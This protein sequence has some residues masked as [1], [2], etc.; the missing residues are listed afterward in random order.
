MFHIC[1]RYVNSLYDHTPNYYGAAGNAAVVELD[2]GDVIYVRSHG[3]SNLYGT[4]HEVYCTFSGHL[5]RAF[6]NAVVGR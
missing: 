4:H 3:A 6:N 1:F 2:A 5:L